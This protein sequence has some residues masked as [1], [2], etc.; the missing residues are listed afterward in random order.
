MGPLVLATLLRDQGLAVEI[1]NFD[2]IFRQTPKYFSAPQE[3]RQLFFKYIENCEADIFGI[4][5]ICSNFPY[6][7]QMASW[8]RQI[9]PRARIILGG[10][11]PSAV[12]K[13]TL[14]KFKFIDGI[15]VGEGEK[16]LIELVNT[17][18]ERNAITQVLGLCFRMGE[19]VVQNP[20]RPLVDDLNDLP[21]P[22][23]TLLDLPAYL[24]VTPHAA[25][26]E[27]GRGCPFRCNFCSTA[28]FWSR[29]YRAKSPERILREMERLYRDYGVSYF[30]LTHD[31]FTTSPKYVREFC[32]YFIEHNTRFKWGSSARTDT[33]KKEDLY[34][35][36]QAG[37]RSLFFGV[38]SGSAS[39][40]KTIEKYLKMDG[41]RDILQEA[42]RLGITV[43]ASFI[44]GFPEETPQDIDDTIRLGIWAKKQGIHEIQFHRLS[45]LAGTKLYHEHR[46]NLELHGLATDMSLPLMN[47]RETLE[48]IMESPDMFSSFYSLPTP[49]LGKLELLEFSNFYTI[50]GNALGSSI[51]WIFEK[52]RQSPL[53]LYQDWSAYVDENYP[54]TAL[55]N[56]T[57]SKEF[58]LHSFSEFL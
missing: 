5:S 3:Y 58:Y 25:I 44:L 51:S 34:K 47:D 41:C 55:K 4:S 13:A 40:Q 18:W 46:K 14:E 16:T 26:I 11:Q 27:A 2:L 43:V 6:A 52:K 49:N 50:L 42:Q 57:R 10:P 7:I 38:D 53:E 24:K 56:G 9:K 54:Q 8:I 35:M 15:V 20:P 22:D 32:R 48:Y 28:E 19:T 39:I 17:P 12:P 33:L 30:P 37:C 1:Q 45:P 36:Y 21:L 29:K 31:N 23:F